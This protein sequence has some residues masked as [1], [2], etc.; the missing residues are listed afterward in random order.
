M[1]RNLQYSPRTRLIRGIYYVVNSIERF[2]IECGK[3][4]TKVITLT[5]HSSCKQHN[6]LIQ[7]HSHSKLLTQTRGKIVHGNL[8]R[9][10]LVFLFIGQ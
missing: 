1:G 2:S 8:S 5:N 4:N 6:E 3:T 9:L 10:V 7:I